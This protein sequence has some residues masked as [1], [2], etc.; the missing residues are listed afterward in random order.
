MLLELLEKPFIQ[1]ML[2]CVVFMLNCIEIALPPKPMKIKLPLSF[3]AMISNVTIVILDSKINETT[4]FSFFAS[5]LVITPILTLVVLVAYGDS[6]S[7]TE[8]K[9]DKEQDKKLIRDP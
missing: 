5:M 4:F 1:M 8:E 3:L 2:L 7:T 6:D 9:T